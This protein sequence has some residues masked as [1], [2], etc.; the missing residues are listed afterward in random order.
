ME[1]RV[2]SGIAVIETL[3]WFAPIKKFEVKQDGIFAK[4]SMYIKGKRHQV[5]SL[6]V[7]VFF[8]ESQK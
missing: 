6:L 1:W 7:K 3:K 8:I 4:F 5:N 2:E